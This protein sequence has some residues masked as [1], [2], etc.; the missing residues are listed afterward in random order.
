MGKMIITAILTAILVPTVVTAVLT[1]IF[2]PDKKTRKNENH[3][4]V[5]VPKAV[6]T[7]GI[8]GAAFILLIMIMV[9]LFSDPASQKM[10]FIFYIICGLFVLLCLYFCIKTKRWKIIVEKESITLVPLLGKKYT[11]TFNDIVYVKRHVTKGYFYME[12]LVIKTKD[13]KKIKVENMLVS[14][15]LFLKRI[16]KEV[17]P[18]F[19]HGFENPNKD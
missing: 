1:S 12:D 3:F 7:L 18:Q 16:E 15:P 9:P 5:C 11:C 4:I 14:Y 19:L 10:I 13:K 6:F 8:F 17:E 2:K